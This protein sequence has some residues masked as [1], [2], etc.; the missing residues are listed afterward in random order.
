MLFTAIHGHMEVI[1]LII[2]T[3]M[4][5]IMLKAVKDIT[6]VRIPIKQIGNIA[7]AIV[8]RQDKAHITYLIIPTGTTANAQ[9]IQAE[10]HVHMV[11]Q[12]EILEILTQTQGHT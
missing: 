10:E 5:I 1:G 6:P 7:M 8:H 2:I 12:Q 4:I 3:T 11:I 9:I